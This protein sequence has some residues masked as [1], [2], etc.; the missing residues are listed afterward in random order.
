MDG[1]VLLPEKATAR[2]GR[3]FHAGFYLPN[4]PGP[5][6]HFLDMRYLQISS[7]YFVAAIDLNDK[8]IA[9]KCAPIIGYM[10]GWDKDKIV[11]YCKKKRWKIEET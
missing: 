11:D 8:G 4:P 10:Y 7:S 6:S 1:Q 5:T 9:V 2:C 3:T